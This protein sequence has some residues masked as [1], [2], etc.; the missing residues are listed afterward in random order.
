MRLLR[1]R[2]QRVTL[3]GAAASVALGAHAAVALM[4][5]R[6][7]PGDPPGLPDAVVIELEPMW[8]EV[9]A[10]EQ[11][12]PGEPQSGADQESE[13]ETLEDPEP[14]AV[15]EPP[16]EAA[17]QEERTNALGPG[18]EPGITEEDLP[19]VRSELALMQSARP[20]FRPVRSVVQPSLQ[21]AEQRQTRQQTAPVVPQDPRQSAPAQVT[22]SRGAGTTQAQVTSWRAQVQSRVNRHMQRARLQGRSGSVQATLSLTVSP[23]GAVSARLATPTGN[24]LIDSALSRQA[25]RMPNLPPPPEGQSVNLTVP[26]IVRLN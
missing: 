18:P 3:W 2:L 21:R 13:Y 19:P 6:V 26:I 5:H 24:G 8:P 14:E 23:S 4:L 12:V 17:P 22:P 20:V 1:W 10:G 16:D 25:A 7:D 9:A 15:E 11:P